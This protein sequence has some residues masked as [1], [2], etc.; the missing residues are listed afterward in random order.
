MNIISNCCAGG[1]IYRDYLKIQYP[2]PFIWCFIPFN[3][4]YTLIKNYKT[5]NFENVELI[6]YNTIFSRKEDLTDFQYNTNV[7]LCID[8]KVKIGWP[9]NYYSPHDSLPRIYNC[10][11]YYNKNWELTLDNWNK[12]IVRSNVKEKPIWLFLTQ[13]IVDFNLENTKKILNDFPDE[14]M[15]VITSFKEL[16]SYNTQKH[17][18]YFN[19]CVERSPEFILK[20]TNL[21][22]DF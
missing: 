20:E 22:F 7:G 8:K 12:R 11:V 4:Y 10:E 5:M 18:I 3:D 21:S 17:K 9:H 16:L 13:N 14:Q 1:Y 2:N 19:R 15:I 6:K